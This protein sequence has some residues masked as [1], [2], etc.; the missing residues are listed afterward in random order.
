MKMS[1]KW[2]SVILCSLALLLI[3]GLSAVAVGLTFTGASI[4]PVSNYDVRSQSASMNLDFSLYG[5]ARTELDPSILYDRARQQTVYIYWYKD[6]SGSGKPSVSGSGIIVSSDGYILTNAHCV[7]DAKA[8]GDPM[9]VELYDGRTYTG[10]IVGADT[11]TDI[12]LLKINMNWLL[13]ATLSNADPKNCQKVYAMGN[14]DETLKFTMTSGIISALDRIV[15]F[16]DGVQLKMFQFDAPVN[17]GN[18]GGPLYDAYGDVIGI[19]TAKYM[20]LNTEGLG[21]AIPIQDAAKIAGELKEYGFVR[22][23]P[24]MGITAISIEA[25]KLKAG[26]PAGV[27][28]HSAEKGLA[29]DRAGLIKGDIIVSINRNPITDMDALSRVKKK[30]S[31]GDT[32]KIRF[33]RDGEYMEAYLTFDEVTPEHPTGPVEIVEEEDNGEPEEKPND[34]EPSEE[35]DPSGEENSEGEQPDEAPVEQPEEAPA[36]EPEVD[37]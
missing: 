32:V 6:N 34:G 10:E 5:T 24:L 8:A 12:A 16:D 21:F 27:M 37:S 30:Y 31:A 15:D 9:Q 33:W 3:L 11:E 2:Q 4:V 1:K 18:S 17:P 35:G 23:R 19:V 22:G 20:S 14:P 29:G 36:D 28:V 13:A 26:S 25:D 7:S